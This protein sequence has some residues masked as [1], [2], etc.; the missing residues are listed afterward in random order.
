MSTLISKLINQP[1]DITEAK[2]FL[3]PVIQGEGDGK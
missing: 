1:S 3:Y 2:Y